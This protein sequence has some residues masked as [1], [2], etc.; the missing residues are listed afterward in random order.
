MVSETGRALIFKI[1][2]N[3][4]KSAWWRFLCI[5]VLVVAAWTLLAWVAAR[6]LVVRAEL[7]HAD[8]LVVLSGSSAYIERTQSAAQLWSEGRAPLVLLTNDPMLGGWIEAERR[9]PS[10]TVR[11]MEELKRAGVA[12]D[13]IEVLP[14]LVTST[15][16]EAVAL[17]EYA[18]ARGLRSILIVTSSYHSRRAL[19]TLRR[20]FQ[21]SGIE[22]GLYAVAPGQQMP[23]PA[24]WWWHPFGWQVVALEYVKLV[25]YLLQYR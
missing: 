8:A 9:N 25:Y 15:Y 2:Q 22:V 18:L 11:A 5:T 20:V 16:E 21:G 19:W 12:A 23:R 17:K 3:E 6:A 7:D 14:Q 13:R 10:F 1:T 4:K 24:T